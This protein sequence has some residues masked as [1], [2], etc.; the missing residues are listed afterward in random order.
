MQNNVF[1]LPVITRIDRNPD[2]ILE[3]LKGQLEGFIL[4]GYDKDGNEVF[5]GTYA[6]GSDVLWLLERC[7]MAL[8]CNDGYSEE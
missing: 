2:I 7:K 5:S 4:A 3:S 1:I 6:D 8:L